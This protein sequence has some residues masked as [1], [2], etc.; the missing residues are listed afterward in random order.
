MTEDFGAAKKRNRSLDAKTPVLVDVKKMA[1]SGSA[2]TTIAKYAPEWDRKSTCE[3]R[4]L[5]SD[6]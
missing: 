3:E 5:G 2:K 4:N 1:V 6:G